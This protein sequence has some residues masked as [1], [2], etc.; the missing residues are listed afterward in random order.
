MAAGNIIAI[1]GYIMLLVA[2]RAQVRYGGTFLV[3]V[4]V[5]PCSAMIMVGDKAAGQGVPSPISSITNLLA[6]NADT[7]VLAFPIGL[8]VEQ[9]RAPLRSRDWGRLHDSLRQ[10]CCVSGYFHLPR[11]GRSELHAWA[12]S[13]I[14]VP[15]VVPGHCLRADGLLPLGESQEGRR[16]PRSEDQRRR[17]SLPIGT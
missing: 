3:A 1:A 7:V 15:C 2:K 4:G 9:P 8:V 13:V 16:R 5:Y 11:Q 10:L 6:N 14:G 12:L 17:G